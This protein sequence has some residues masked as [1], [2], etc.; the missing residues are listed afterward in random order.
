VNQTT[1]T[2]ARL[3]RLVLVVAVVAVTITMVVASVLMN[4]ALGPKIVIPGPLSAQHAMLTDDCLN[5]HS[6][7]MDST[8]GVLHGIVSSEL[9][10]R[11]SGLCLDCHDLGGDPMQAHGMSG[12]ALQERTLRSI[13][14]PVLAGANGP[15]GLRPPHSKDGEYACA[16][17]H[18]EHEG[19]GNDLKTMSEGQ[20]QSCHSIRFDSFEKGHPEFEGYPYRRRLRIAFD[21][22]SHIYHNFLTKDQGLAPTACTDCHSVDASGEFMRTASF[23]MTC[24]KCHEKDVRA[25]ARSG[26]AGIAVLALPAIDTMSLDDAGI[27]IGQWPADSG[28]A[29]GAITPFMRMM[30]SGDAQAQADLRAIEELDLLDLQGA[31]QEELEAVARVVWSIKALALE[32][33]EGGHDVIAGRVSVGASSNLTGALSRSLA[34]ECI[35]AWL[36]DLASDL[37]RHAAGDHPQTDLLEDAE[38]EEVDAT[39]QGWASLGGWY[40]DD[41]A[42]AIKYRPTGHGDPFLRAWSELAASNPGQGKQ[43][44]DAFAEEKAVGQCLKCH[45][46]DRVKGGAMKVNWWAGGR[47]DLDNTLTRFDHAP[48]LPLLGEEGCLMCHSIEPQAREFELSY[49]QRDPQVFVSSMASMDREGCAEC[50]TPKKV[51]TSCLDCHEYHAH[52]PVVRLRDGAPLKPIGAS[53]ESVESAPDPIE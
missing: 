41:M 11:D 40:R 29:E 51:A 33:S 52:R 39:G 7:E 42:F 21:H 38:F 4:T 18:V 34:R 47:E 28:V 24:A 9:S 23:E 22:A 20:C 27:G 31:T 37:E 30:L 26:G 35:E 10:L 15:G 50:H 3:A 43:L 19:R 16:V 46:V 45:S 48:H 44:L 32:I 2:T 14:S 13:S 5:C 49:W 1:P 17:C 8:K 53:D 6:A 25:T 12:I 36:P